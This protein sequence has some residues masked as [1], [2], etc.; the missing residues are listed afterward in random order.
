VTAVNPLRDVRVV[1]FAFDP[2]PG[3]NSEN[4]RLTGA[5]N[6]IGDRRVMVKRMAEQLASIEPAPISTGAC[7]CWQWRIKIVQPYT[8]D[9]EKLLKAVD[10]AIMTPARRTTKCPT[11]SR[12][13]R[14]P[15]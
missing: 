14:P 15:Q 2:L 12:R 9:K 1:T 11:R 8:T 3:G 4:A 5:G 10:K 7:S 6:K 13:L